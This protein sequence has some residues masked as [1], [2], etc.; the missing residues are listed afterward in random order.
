MIEY[1]HEGEQLVWNRALDTALTLSM[2][3]GEV[4]KER[5][6]V[7]ARIEISMNGHSLA[8]GVVNV[9]KD[10]DRVRMSNSAW[11]QVNGQAALFDKPEM[12]R[13]FDAFCKGLWEASLGPLAPTLMEG[14]AVSSPPTFAL[15]PYL[16]Q[17][18]GTIFFAH[19]GRGKSYLVKLMAVH[20][21]AG[22]EIPAEHR[23]WPVRQQR[24]LWINLERGQAGVQARLGN[25]NAALGLP[26]PRPLL[27]MNARGRSLADILPA[28]ERAV[29]E[30]HIGVVFLDSI[31]RAGLG[32]LTENNPVNRIMDALNGLA[33]TWGAIAH[34]PRSSDEHLYGSIHFEAGADVVVRLLSQQDE[35]GP[36]GIGLFVTKENDIGK[37]PPQIL[38]LE[39]GPSGLTA[40]R[41]AQKGEFPEVEKGKPQSM[42][43]VVIDYLLGVGDAT[44]TQ[45]AGATKYSRPNVSELLGHDPAFIPTR[46][47]GVQQFYGVAGLP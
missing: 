24:V 44:A 4:R 43:R 28:A 33:P 1:A 35:A 36:L 10:E 42:K 32:D 29:R 17:G 6:G 37:P 38:A 39:F 3:A 5:T 30:Q 15:H 21:D 22:A 19:P 23:L 7:H 20:L 45:I 26:R 13:C 14:A 2:S 41:R 46:K 8:W 9:D 27:T 40:A 25:I 18:G 47:L 31:S 34:A 16:V 12:K 11:G